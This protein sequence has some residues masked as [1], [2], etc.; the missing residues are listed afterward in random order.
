MEGN[1]VGIKAIF[2][3]ESHHNNHTHTKQGELWD[4][5][6][7]TIV[8]FI[9][10]L[11]IDNWGDYHVGF[12]KAGPLGIINIKRGR[13]EK[14]YLETRGEQVRPSNPMHLPEG[15]YSG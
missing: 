14:A 2:E 12:G 7:A 8:R 6:E 3:R 13:H 4:S 11:D 5:Q 1:K 10:R 9:S 15:L